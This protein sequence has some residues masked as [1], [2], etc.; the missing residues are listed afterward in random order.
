MSIVH[1]HAISRSTSAIEAETTI[2]G[3][4]LGCSSPLAPTTYGY[5]QFS[6]QHRR[7]PV[8]DRVRAEVDRG[9]AQSQDLDTIE[10]RR[11]QHRP[12]LAAQGAFAPMV[13][14][15]SPSWS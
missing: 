13:A 6:R 3:V 9:L 15:D 5:S 1:G 4:G 8:T 7:Q 10:E 12:A 11:C 14:L 2:N